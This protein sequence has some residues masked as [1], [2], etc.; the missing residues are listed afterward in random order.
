MA[1]VPA[2]NDSEGGDALSR[3]RGRGVASQVCFLPVDPTALPVQSVLF[4]RC[5]TMA[6]PVSDAQK[7]S[8]GALRGRITS[9]I[10]A[11]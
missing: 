11:A 1:G 6:D 4:G 9:S 5:G 10:D 3:S 2:R 7:C 8:S